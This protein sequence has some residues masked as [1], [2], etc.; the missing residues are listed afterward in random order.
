[1]TA[2]PGVP[3][4]KIHALTSLRFFAAFWV[5]VF[6]S[7][8]WYRTPGSTFDNITNVGS[9]SVSF[10]FFLSGYILSVVY[11]RNRSAIDRPKFYIARFARIYPLFVVTLMA[12]LPF[13]LVARIHK[14]GLA[15]A[16]EKTSVTLFANLIMLQAW[17]LNLR[18][19]DNPNW[20]L[21]VETVFYI[22][23]PIAGF[24]LWHRTRNQVLVLGIFLW[25]ASQVIVFVAGKHFSHDA[26]LFFPLLHVPTFVLGILFARL[27]LSPVSSQAV[28]SD[29]KVLLFSSLV[30]L[31]GCGLVAVYFKFIPETMLRDGILVPVYCSLI[32][33]FSL[34]NLWPARIVSHPWLVILGEASYGLYLIHL[35]VFHL[36][37]ALHLDAHIS[38]YPLYLILCIGLSVLSFFFF[39]APARRAI[40]A[41]FHTRSRE[42]LEAAS[43]AQ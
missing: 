39:E 17:I 12:D 14:Y 33:I 11:L 30:L 42:T 24:W 43:D 36:W 16:I 21:A 9:A 41:R 15:H 10:F 38:L 22:I 4:T 23:F 26:V 31:V 28:S 35:P 13:L 18:G 32:A 1:M 27:H 20:S 40:L 8:L 34:N 6:H 5:V 3:A 25:V 37:E 19:L 29:R 7:F 2:R